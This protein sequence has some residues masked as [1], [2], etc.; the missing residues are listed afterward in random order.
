MEADLNQKKM[1]GA[2][3]LSDMRMWVGS[4]EKCAVIYQI[5]D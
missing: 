2:K 3:H 4:Y 5:P 1:L